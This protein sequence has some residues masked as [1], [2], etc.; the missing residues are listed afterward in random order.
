MEFCNETAINPEIQGFIDRATY[1]KTPEVKKFIKEHKDILRIK[2]LGKS[3]PNSNPI[4]SLVNKLLNSA[5]VVDRLRQ[6]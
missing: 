6:R 2:F 3:D 1:H 5:V 4:E